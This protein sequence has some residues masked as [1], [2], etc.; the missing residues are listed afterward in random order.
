[1]P[2][3]RRAFL[4]LKNEVERLPDITQEQW[5]QCVHNRFASE[6]VVV[7]QLPETFI[8]YLPRYI[9]GPL[10]RYG[11]V[12]E[13]ENGRY[14]ISRAGITRQFVATVLR[15]I[16]EFESGARDSQP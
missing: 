7:G 2:W 3:T 9:S 11:K 4:R 12:M 10:D 14:P 1:V 16:D 5:I 13:A 8:P 15:E 6:G